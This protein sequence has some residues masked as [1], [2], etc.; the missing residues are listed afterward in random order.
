[1]M[2]LSISSFEKYT[3]KE[4]KK[5]HRLSDKCDYCE[6]AKSIKKLIENEIL[7]FDYTC[8]TYDSD[9]LILY[10]D[11]LKKKLVNELSS[12]NSIV[13]YDQKIK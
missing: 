2:K 1:M 4:F 10:L 6:E 5:P 9:H 8:V 11:D 13:N 12:S 7:K 3:G